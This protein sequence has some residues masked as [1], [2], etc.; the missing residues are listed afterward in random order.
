MYALT[1]TEWR[2]AVMYALAHTD[3]EVPSCMHLH[4]RM[5][6]WPLGFFAVKLKPIDK[7]AT[8]YSTLTLELSAASARHEGGCNF[9]PFIC[10]E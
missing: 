7:N 10:G 8:F 3:G 1:H 9:K 6:E 2:I 5:G 4:T